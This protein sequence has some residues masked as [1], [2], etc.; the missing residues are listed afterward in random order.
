M[1]E[2]VA[3]LC[4]SVGI[5]VVMIALAKVIEKLIGFKHSAESRT[6]RM[7]FIAIFSAISAVLMY[8]E[9]PL[10]FAPSFYKLDFSE[11][12][13]LI[14]GFAYGPMAGV[15]TE[16]LKVVLKLLLKG[17]STNYVGDLASFIIGCMLI[18]PAA[19]VY[20]TKKT[21]KTAVI[22]LIAGT[23]LMTAFGSYFNAVYLI[24]TYAELF[25]M[26]IDVI[27]GMGNKVNSHV[28]GVTSLVLLCVVPFNIL[29]GVADS[30][31][32][33]LLY[34]RLSPLIHKVNEEQTV[35]KETAEVKNEAATTE[36]KAETEEKSEE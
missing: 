22:G 32:T 3:F 29:K 25:G 24:P 31:L 26:P 15:I 20:H 1:S 17:T 8:F 4:A 19:C 30:V 10:W 6:R 28:T 34:K 18:F 5:I 12:P 23:F 35:V 16:F 14:C 13:V 11:L 7:V 21:R 36:E 9:V 27:V 33:F 2:S